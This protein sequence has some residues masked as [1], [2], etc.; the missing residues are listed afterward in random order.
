MGD[1]PYIA[2]IR[3]DSYDRDRS[4]KAVQ[5]PERERSC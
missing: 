5:R 1:I 2:T 4:S 3:V